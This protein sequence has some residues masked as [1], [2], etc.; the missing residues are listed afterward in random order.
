MLLAVLFCSFVV[1]EGV[2]NIAEIA[3]SSRQ[4]GNESAGTNPSPNTV[5]VFVV[6]GSEMIGSS[7]S[8]KPTAPSRAFHIRVI[9]R[10][11]SESLEQAFFSWQCLVVACGTLLLFKS[12]LECPFPSF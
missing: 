7:K 4:E 2:I 6:P 11:L 9:P 8:R 12:R 5:A 3:R 10:P 1:T